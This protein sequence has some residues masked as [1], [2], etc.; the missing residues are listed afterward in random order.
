[1]IMTSL[2]RT[3][4]LNMF[5]KHET[6]TLTDATLKEN[7]GMVPHKDHFQFLLEELKESGHVLQLEGPVQTT[8]TITDKGI[9]EAERLEEE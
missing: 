2:N 4:V 6:L 9:A 3:L 8:Y 7:L 5:I 1:M